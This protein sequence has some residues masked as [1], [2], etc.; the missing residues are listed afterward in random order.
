MQD[1]LLA[2]DSVAVDQVDRPA[3]VGDSPVPGEQ[4]DGVGGVVLDPDVIDPEPLSRLDPR[5][6]G[7]KI[8]CDPNRYPR[9]DPSVL[10]EIYPRESK[11]NPVCAGSQLR[12]STARSRRLG[13]RPITSAFEV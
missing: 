11:P 6:F 3:R 13:H 1:R 12:D 4:L 2:N 10:E 8:D 9:G 5:L 7:Q